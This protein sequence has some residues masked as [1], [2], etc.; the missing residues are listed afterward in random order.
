[1]VNETLTVHEEDIDSE[2]LEHE[3]SPDTTEESESKT[4]LVHSDEEVK[5]LYDDRAL[6]ETYSATGRRKRAVARVIV[7][8]GTGK[9]TVNS[10]DASDYFPGELFIQHIEEPLNA[11]ELIGKFD[12]HANVHGG[13]FSGQAGAIRH[14]ISRS[15]NV[16]ND[17][18][19]ARLKAKGMLTRDSREKERKKYGKRGARASFQFSKR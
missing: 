16:I 19:R 15:L 11:T 17:R 9:I 18:M 5:P 12:I 6:K 14:G 8:P 3:L 1:M 4:E 2:T 7:S 10:R 13:G